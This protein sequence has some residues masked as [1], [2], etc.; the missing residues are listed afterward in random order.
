MCAP[1]CAM[2]ARFH[3]T[4]M[5]TV[6]SSTYGGTTVSAATKGSVWPRAFVRRERVNEHDGNAFGAWR[7]LGRPRSPDLRT[8]DVLRDCARPALDEPF[9]PRLWRC[10]GG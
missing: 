8:L 3:Q 7:E 5:P 6:A 9:A 2:S 10:R 1:N 4:Q